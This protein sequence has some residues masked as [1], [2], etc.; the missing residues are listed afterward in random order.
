MHGLDREWVMALDLLSFDSLVR[1][2][3]RIDAIER[4]ES[5]WI[6]MIAAQG[7]SETMKEVL[8][9]GKKLLKP[10]EKPQQSAKQEAKKGMAEFLAKFPKGF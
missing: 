3:Q 9:S 5:A 2:C 10:Y 6:G 4:E 1:S 7:K 8:D